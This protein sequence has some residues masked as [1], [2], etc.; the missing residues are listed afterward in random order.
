VRLSRSSLLAEFILFFVCT[1]TQFGL[2]GDRK[3]APTPPMGWNSWDSYGR[4]ITETQFKANVDWMAAHLKQFGWQYMVIDEGWYV[5]NPA[6]DPKDY[7]FRMSSDG[8]FLPVPDRFPSAAGNAGFKAVADYVHAKGLKFGIHML[9][10]VPREAVA[11]NTPIANFNFDAQDAGDQSDACP[12]N[13][14]NWGVKDSEAGQAYY[15]S[16]IRLYADW[17]VDFL[18]VDCIANNPYKSDEIRMIHEAIRKTGRPIVLSLSPG[19]TALDHVNE[20]AKYAEMWRISN[21]L[22]DHWGPWENHDWSQS[23]YNQFAT[24]ASWASHVSPGNWPDAD[25]L[26]LGWL[27]PHPGEGEPRKTKFTKD[28][29]QTLMTLW[30]IF[31]SPLIMGGDLLSMDEWTTSLLTNTEVIRVNQLSSQ[32]RPIVTSGKLAIWHAVE[33]GTDA[34]HRDY[35]AVFNLSN[36]EQTIHYEW[37]D[38]GL[39]AGKYKLRDIW[40]RESAGTAE[41]LTVKLASHASVL[42][43]ADAAR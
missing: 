15:D 4:T 20:V 27:G 39:A 38:V 1:S 24:A 10:G 11:K 12:W 19:P 31:R 9:R 16:E 7:T 6:S 43:S 14:Y 26:P 36:S 34:W 33:Q 2:A 28:E 23:L 40:K 18:K 8:R 25:M 29:Q 41:S 37:K 17:G 5:V 21:D 42:Y 35:I 3:L 32:N 13:A 30:A 22:W